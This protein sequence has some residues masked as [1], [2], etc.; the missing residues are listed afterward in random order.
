MPSPTDQTKNVLD[1]PVQSWWQG[2]VTG[3]TGEPHPVSPGV[4]GAIEDGQ[5]TLTGEV[6]S[7]TELSAL[8]AEADGQRQRFRTLDNQV[9]VAARES[10]GDG[11]LS[12]TIVALFRERS[13]ADFTVAFLH[14]HAGVNTTAVQLFDAAQIAGGESKLL[15]VDQQ[16]ELTSLGGEGCCFVF[17]TVDEPEAFR[18]RRIMDEECGST[19]TLV[20]PPTA[21][22][23]AS[24]RDTDE[25]RAR[26]NT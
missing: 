6:E 25:A 26:A 13:Q 11:I 4:R 18:V 7:E 21:T 17:A 14:E 15:P 10:A 2:L 19:A 8:A 1:A 12:Q 9:T 23:G 3:R 20:L 5:L 22:A 24:A 16:E